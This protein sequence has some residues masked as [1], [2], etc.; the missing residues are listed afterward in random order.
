MILV[1]IMLLLMNNSLCCAYLALKVEEYNLNVDQFVHVL[2]TELRAPAAEM[3]LSYE[4][5]PCGGWGSTGI[6]GIAAD[7]DAETTVSLNGPQPIQTTRGFY[8]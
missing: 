3:I 4:V 7:D 5:S 6:V 8:Y 1:M 2:M